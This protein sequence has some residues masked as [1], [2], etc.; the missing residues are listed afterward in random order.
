[1]RP[2]RVELAK[3]FSKGAAGANEKKPPG[4][5]SGVAPSSLSDSSGGANER[6]GAY[7]RFPGPS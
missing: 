1:M 3:L 6:A 7:G 5:L 2:V 4:R